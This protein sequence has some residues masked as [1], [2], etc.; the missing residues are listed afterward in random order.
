MCFRCIAVIFHERHPIARPWGR[1]I[2]CRL[3]MSGRSCTIVTAVLCIIVLYRESTVIW[4]HKQH[5][6]HKNSH[7]LINLY[8]F[9]EQDAVLPVEENLL[10]RYDGY[11]LHHY[12]NSYIDKTVSSYWNSFSSC[13]V[14][15]DMQL[16]KLALT[17]LFMLPCHVSW[18][19]LVAVHF[20]DVSC[21]YM[22]W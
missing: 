18:H 13:H 17:Y 21:V 22:C 20:D 15:T 12:G 5:S 9:Q 3:L 11:T 6:S 1:D 10:W 19:S 8:R 7:I 16:M 14:C 4:C 2:G